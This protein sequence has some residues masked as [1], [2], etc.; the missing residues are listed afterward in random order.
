MR[1]FL[2]EGKIS[3]HIYSKLVDAVI[4]FSFSFTTVKLVNGTTCYYSWKIVFFSQEGFHVC[5]YVMH[6]VEILSPSPP[7]EVSPYPITL[8]SHNV[9]FVHPLGTLFLNY[10]S[11][12]LLKIFLKHSGINWFQSSRRALYQ[13]SH[14]SSPACDFNLLFSLICCWG[15]GPEKR[16]TQKSGACICLCM[17]TGRPKIEFVGVFLCHSP[18]YFC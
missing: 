7:L 13:L 6:F 18:Y 12:K 15:E 16:R 5:M 1:I 14:I 11:C 10:V 2:T 3:S 4:S 9:F 8:S 17:C